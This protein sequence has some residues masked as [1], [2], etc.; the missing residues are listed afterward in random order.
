MFQDK[1]LIARKTTSSLIEKMFVYCGY[2]LSHDDYKSI[3]YNEK[4]CMTNTED[5][6]K[7]YYDGYLYL[8][9][10]SNNLLSAKMISIFY[11]ILKLEELS[12]TTINNIIKRHISTK[13]MSFYEQAIELLL[14]IKDEIKSIDKID[15]LLIPLMFF[16]YILVKNNIPSI[17]LV[18]NDIIKYDE[19]LND[20]KK[21][22]L[23][24]L[25]KNIINE[26]EFYDKSYFENLNDLSLKEII[27]TF[28]KDKDELINKYKVIKLFIYGS[29]AKGI[30]RYD[31]D[32]D[33]LIKLDDDL[34]YEERLNII[35]ELK[36]RYTNIF[37]R[38]VDIEEISY[39]FNDE[40]IKEIKDIKIIINS[41]G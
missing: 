16:N 29:Y 27:S 3:L 19:L 38:F 31:S 39:F 14:I 18:R 7:R 24:I 33:L 12:S 28:K 13:D 37:K 30:N 8:L 9:N 2:D 4:T 20:N 40:Y 1:Q 32:I 11:Y 21:E 34:L 25:F 5:K 26:Y 35:K 15:N 10:N 41:K 36:E 22:E 17:R 6:I 23:F